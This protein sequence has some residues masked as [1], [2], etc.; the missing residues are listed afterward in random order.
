MSRTKFSFLNITTGYVSYFVTFLINFIVRTIFIR[1]LGTSFLGIEGLFSNI[2]SFL[3]LADLG[4]SQA[5]SYKLYRAIADDDRPKIFALLEFYRRVFFLVGGIIMAVGVCLIPFL[6]S[7]VKD[8]GRFAEL[9][10]SGVAVLLIYLFNNSCSY[11]C[12]S[13][14]YTFLNAQQHVYIC[15]LVFAAFA[16]LSGAAQIL[17]LLLFHRSST[18]FYLYLLAQGTF[19]VLSYLVIA[20]FSDRRFPYS[21]GR[22]KERIARAE[23]RGM[24]NDCSAT[25]LRKLQNVVISASDSLV[26]SAFLGLD[27]VGLY[28]NYYT[29]RA[30]ISMLLNKLLTSLSG[31]V[32]NLNTEGNDRW[33]SLV[34]HAIGLLTSFLFGVFGIGTALILN[35]FITCWV[36][37]DFVVTSFTNAAGETVLAPLA[38]LC[39][40]EI[41][42]RG[43]QIYYDLFR[44]T[45][46]LFRQFRIRPVL[47]IL[48]NLGV[49]L[50]TVR[51]FGICGCVL[52]TIACLLLTVVPAEPC[53]ICKKG[54]HESPWPYFRRQALYTLVLVI[55]GLAAR[56]ICLRLPI[57]GWLGFFVHGVVCVL[58]PA[59]FFL[60]CF[61]RTR[62]FR[63]LKRTILDLLRKKNTKTV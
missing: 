51:Q 38:L 30:S 12:F 2:L 39:G 24:L 19:C 29:V 25:L 53:I 35:E 56:W 34:F 44:E 4:I 37:A 45:L 3:S 20:F 18:A 49:S 14:K 52:G 15:N 6:P 60:L 58:V 40:L 36:G 13:Y 33:T 1:T 42:F 46:G 23:R 55:G 9:G 27:Q 26:L 59:V 16:L 54:L 22:H 32:G 57:A 48:V 50:L 62:E 43:L 10:L 63:Y 7:L 11:W 31:S 28:S 41:Y 17:I 61:F 21:R 5:I 47:T 8:Y